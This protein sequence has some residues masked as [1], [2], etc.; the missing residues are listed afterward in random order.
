MEDNR[1]RR[2]KSRKDR[3][4]ENTE[5]TVDRTVD[6]TVALGTGDGEPTA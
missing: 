6:L 4:G 3:D 2:I 5:E 1:L